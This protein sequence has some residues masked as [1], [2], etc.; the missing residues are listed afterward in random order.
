MRYTCSAGLTSRPS[1]T[2]CSS[3]RQLLSPV[4]R[5]TGIDA[6][7]CVVGMGEGAVNEPSG[8]V[9]RCDSPQAELGDAVTGQ[10]PELGQLD[11]LRDGEL[12]VGLF[13]EQH[14]ARQLVRRQPGPEPVHDVGRF[15]P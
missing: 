14:G 8:G 6:H 9:W 3:L 4:W 2:M 7:R 5:T 1:P 10:L 13:D 12:E 15:E 11:L